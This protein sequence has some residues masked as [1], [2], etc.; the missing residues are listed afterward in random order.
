MPSFNDETPSTSMVCG[1]VTVHEF[2]AMIPPVA[3]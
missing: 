3:I 1:P 2:S